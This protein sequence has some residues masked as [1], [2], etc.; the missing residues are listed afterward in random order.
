MTVLGS[1]LLIRPTERT[2]PPLFL[3]SDCAGSC[4][5]LPASLSSSSTSIITAGLAPHSPAEVLAE[6][7]FAFSPPVS[8]GNVGDGEEESE[9]GEEGSE[10]EG[11]LE[12]ASAIRKTDEPLVSRPLF[13]SDLPSP[14]W[15]G[16]VQAWAPV[17]MLQSTDGEDNDEVPHHSSSCAVAV[18]VFPE[19]DE[20]M[21]PRIS[22]I[23]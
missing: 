3:F 13:P 19:K 7:S 20:C 5:L 1:V 21:R 17:W 23:Q 22:A 2:P 4:P 6:A 9:L 12:E 10:G 18:Q 14:A 8:L 11:L 15:G 16:D